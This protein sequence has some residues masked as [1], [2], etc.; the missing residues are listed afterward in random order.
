MVVFSVALSGLFPLLAILSR[1]L[2]PLRQK[3]PRPRTTASR[4]PGTETPPAATSPISDTPGILRP[5]TIRGSANSAR[6]AAV[7]STAPTSAF[8]PVPIQ[9]AVVFQDDYEPG[10][11]TPDD[12]PGSYAN[13]GNWTYQPN[14]SDLLD[15]HCDNAPLAP[16]TTTD[17]ATWNLSVTTAGWYSIQATWP[18]DFCTTHPGWSLGT[19]QYAVTNNGTAVANSPFSVDQSQDVSTGINDAGRVWWNV[20][21][22]PVWLQKGTVAV[23][24]NILPSAS[25]ACYVLA[26][27]IQ[28]VRNDVIIKSL[29]RS[30]S[31]MNG[32]SDGSDVAVNV[33]ITVNLCK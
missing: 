10:S 24:L 1:D 25:D 17:N 21:T 14:G 28:I 30:L 22:G 33:S 5:I 31:Q 26:D 16:A 6:V 20:T 12:G 19:V 9:P 29:Q 4:R 15:Y 2:Q 8:S 3:R 11:M 32:N 18:P 27:G 7:A 23:T 13:V